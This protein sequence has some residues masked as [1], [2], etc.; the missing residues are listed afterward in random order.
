[1]GITGIGTLIHLTD[2]TQNSYLQKDSYFQIIQYF[3]SPDLLKLA[4]VQFGLQELQVL[5]Y[6]ISKPMELPYPLVFKK[7]IEVQNQT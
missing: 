4:I 3:P 2:K 7:R 5:V 1:M 6:D